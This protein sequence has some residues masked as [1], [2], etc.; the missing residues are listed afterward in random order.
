MRVVRRVELAA[1]GGGSPDGLAGG[2]PSWVGA[3]GYRNDVSPRERSGI[4]WPEVPAF[5][6]T[7][8]WFRHRGDTIAGGPLPAAGPN[9]EQMHH[10][11]PDFVPLEAQ[12]AFEA[13]V[14]RAV[15]E[16]GAGHLEKV[17]LARSAEVVAPSG[18]A[19]DPCA[20]LEI[21]LARHAAS[22][23]FAVGDGRRTFLGATP[24]TLVSVVRG[25]LETHAVAGTA[26]RA[27]DSDEDQALGRR[28]LES[29][30]DREEQAV[31]ARAI[32]ARLRPFVVGLEV[33]RVQ[34]LRLPAVQHLVSPIRA[35]L[36]PGVTA[37]ALAQALHPTP[38]VGGYPSAEADAWLRAEEPLDRGLYAGPVG[39]T[40]PSGDGLFAVAIRSA[41]VSP[42]RAVAFAGAGIVR[43]S[44]PAA[45][46][47]ETELKLATIGSALR[48]VETA[49]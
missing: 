18:Y 15:A 3:M 31:V 48:L 43:G 24:E 22:I 12:S 27:A 16:I 13:R 23:V 49:S 10:R 35:R 29:E 9:L 21:L 40:T 42:E 33:G 26:P 4:A 47:H 46:W 32:A 45:E 36:R 1:V 8:C 20:I 44:E 14:G 39:F 41:V 6:P 11:A 2:L 37:Q 25:E 7:A 17:V 5:V 28:L 30:K 34:L 19:F 38:A